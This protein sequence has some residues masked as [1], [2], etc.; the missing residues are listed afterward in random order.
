MTAK[1]KDHLMEFDKKVLDRTLHDWMDAVRTAVHTIT[2]GVFIVAGIERHRKLIIDAT[3]SML[4]E[5]G[6]VDP[7][8]IPRHPIVLRMRPFEDFYSYSRLSGLEEAEEA[9]SLAIFRPVVIEM[10]VMSVRS[11]FR[12][13]AGTGVH[14]ADI[15]LIKGIYS[16]TGVPSAN[17]E[18]MVKDIRFFA[19]EAEVTRARTDEFNSSED[20]YFIGDSLR[21]ISGEGISIED[22]KNRFPRDTVVEIVQSLC[23]A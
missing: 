12:R 15:G 21:K 14:D 11:V 8:V 7:T 10:H 3:M 18:A 13:L 22:V 4:K 1:Q 17:G 23:A 6:P 16:L 9:F 2:P 19:N 5:A 20:R